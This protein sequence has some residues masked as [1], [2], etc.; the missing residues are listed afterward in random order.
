MTDE[1][2]TTLAR[3]REMSEKLD[4]ARA[5]GAEAYARM[6]DNA[7]TIRQATD[8]IGNTL[9]GTNM[10]GAIDIFE[11][12]VPTLTDLMVE[13]QPAIDLYGNAME[14]SQRAAT[15][16]VI[17]VAESNN[18]KPVEAIGQGALA[19]LSW[20]SA[21]GALVGCVA[22]IGEARDAPQTKVG[23]LLT[24][25]AGMMLMAEDEHKDAV[26]A[27]ETCKRLIE[28]YARMI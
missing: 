20:S 27:V 14:E 26:I 7:Q 11:T 19:Q 25:A 8:E 2:A 23:E 28:E 12:W 13:I 9:P 17:E 21:S 3:L 15:G 10:Q 5:W 4:Q 6:E 18:E 1:R 16:I 22:K 24:E